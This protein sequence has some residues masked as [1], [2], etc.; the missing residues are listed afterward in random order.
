MLAHIEPE[1]L[2]HGVYVTQDGVVIHDCRYRPIVSCPHADDVKPWSLFFDGD[3][4]TEWQICFATEAQA[5]PSHTRID[6]H[7]HGFF[8]PHDK[9]GNEKTQAHVRKLIESIPELAAEIQ[10]RDLAEKAEKA[11]QAAREASEQAALSR[12]DALMLDVQAAE[13]IELDEW[14][15][16]RETEKPLRDR[17]AAL[18]G[19]NA[20]NRIPKNDTEHEWWFAIVGGLWGIQPEGAIENAIKYFENKLVTRDM[21]LPNNVTPLKPAAPQPDVIKSSAEFVRN[22]TPPDYTIDGILQRRFFYCMTARPGAGKTSVALLFAALVATKKK[23]GDIDVEQ[24]TVL[25]MAGENP[26]D[27][28]MRWIGLSQELKFDPEAVD[29]HWL[30]GA[31]DLAQNAARISAEVARKGLKP[32]MVI[33]DTATAYNFGDDENSNAQ[34]VGY[35]RLLRSLTKLPGE[36]TVIVL[37]HPPKNAADDCLEPRG[38]GAFLAEV[39]GNIGVKK[40]D[41]VVTLFP[42]KFRGNDRWSIV[43]NLRTV[44][45]PRLKDTKGRDISTVVAEAVTEGEAAQMAATSRRHEDLVLKSVETHPDASLTD[46]AIALRWSYKSGKP[47]KTK[48]KRALDTLESEKLIR[49]KR[50]RWELTGAGEVELNRLDLKKPAAVLTPMFPIETLPET[51][52]PPMPPKSA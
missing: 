49:G 45:H 7:D 4:E 50:G 23:L 40:K 10:R 22:F 34:Q 20:K 36:P 31:M 37:C 12:F 21:P 35:A 46:R 19:A 25:Y 3:D 32:S 44:Y 26:S 11:E 33:V 48:V 1:L 9:I 16:R 27:V 51:G 52:G 8:H 13:V 47:D 17:V 41:S 30:E 15:A 2:P 5:V 28:Q 38:G 43:C 39:D 14:R 42:T 29:V 6:H 18:E 24:G